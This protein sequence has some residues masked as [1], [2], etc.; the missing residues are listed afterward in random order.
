MTRAS[1]SR[2]RLITGVYNQATS[3][4]TYGTVPATTNSRKNK[5][6]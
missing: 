3:D 6:S 1:K 2:D 4:I 5:M